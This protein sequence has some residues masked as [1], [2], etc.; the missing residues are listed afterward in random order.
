LVKALKLALYQFE[1]YNDRCKKFSVYAEKAIHTVYVTFATE[2]GFL[3]CLKKY[4]NVGP[5]VTPIIQDEELR[6]KDKSG[7]SHVVY[8]TQSPN[9]SEIVW[10][11]VPVPF[12]SVLFRV[13][14][15]TVATIL[16][17]GTSY[18]MIQEAKFLK[19]KV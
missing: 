12:I 16:F 18:T 1:Y 11:N 3:R 6:L 9:P 10:E 14:L 8:I 7:K 17:L 13:L 2:I 4:P 19:S 5:L 15:T